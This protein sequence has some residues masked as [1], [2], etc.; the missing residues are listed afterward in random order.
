MS[1]AQEPSWIAK[2]SGDLYNPPYAKGVPA[3]SVAPWQ[4]LTSFK[5]FNYWCEGAL[6]HT[7]TH[8]RSHTPLAYAYAFSRESCA[9]R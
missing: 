9:V 8:T 2:E 4:R 7:H 3:G 1:Q 6:T 5:W